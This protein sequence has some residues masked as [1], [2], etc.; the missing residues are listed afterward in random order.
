MI[1]L[2]N[3]IELPD[4]EGDWYQEYLDYGI[5]EALIVPID[6]G[7]YQPGATLSRGELSDMIYRLIKHPFT[8][9]VELGTGTY[10]ADMFVGRGTANGETYSHE[11]LTAAHPTLPFH[12]M[13]KVTNVHT[14]LSVEVRVNDRGPYAGDHIIDLTQSAFDTIGNLSSGIL[15]LRIEI[16]EE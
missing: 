6:Y 14:N 8:G 15:D 9:E 1:T 3:G 10:Y 2:A 16:L 7:D 4:S 11:E 12:T 5:E 13:L